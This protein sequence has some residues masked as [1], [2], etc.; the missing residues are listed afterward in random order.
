MGILTFTATLSLDGYVADANGD[1]Q[2]AGPGDAVFQAHIDRLTQVSTEVHGRRT[3]QLMAY[4]DAEPE[5]GA[6]SE[7]EHEWARLWAATD[8]VV[9]SST[10]A[11][12]DVS[13]GA[14]LVPHLGLDELE[15]V[16]RDAAGD[17]EIF[18]PTTA[19]PALRAGLV[20]ELRLYVVP[21]VVGGGLRAFPEGV[22]LDLELV[23]QARLDAVTYLRLRRRGRTS[24]H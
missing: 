14:R 22:D 6:W 13:A 11:P 23:E 7:A 2:W 15:Q 1:F 18:G 17:V 3:H 8:K 10:L 12:T 4:W 19:A 21:K 20:E 16:V 24:E 9:V 5:P